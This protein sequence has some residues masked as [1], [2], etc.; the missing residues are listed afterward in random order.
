MPKIIANSQMTV[1]SLTL[2]VANLVP[3]VGV[4]WLGWDA[5]SLVLLFWLENVIIGF[6]NILRMVTARGDGTGAVAKKLFMIPFFTIHY[7][8]FT[9]AQGVLLFSIFGKAAGLESTQ[10]GEIPAMAWQQ[11][12]ALGLGLT[13]LTLFASHG[14]SFLTNTLA[15]GEYKQARV[16]TLMGRPYGR[17]M[18]M[19]FTV[20]IGGFLAQMTGSNRWALLVLVVAKL[21]VDLASH[22]KE[23]KIFAG[24]SARTTGTS[25]RRVRSSLLRAGR[26]D[27][28]ESS[29]APRPDHS[30]RTDR[31]P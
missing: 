22:Q 1:S 6:F 9:L 20:L 11:V 3:L 4:F 23:R 27:R 14:V 28:G 2:V 10:P 30:T 13:L 19:Q 26:P 31:E 21:V 24:G 17:I 18:I 7:G 12:V 25:G 16:D 8:F 15:A 5:F 29:A